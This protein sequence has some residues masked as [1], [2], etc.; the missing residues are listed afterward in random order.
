[1]DKAAIKGNVTYLR[2]DYA[3]RTRLELRA[4]ESVQHQR[5][6]NRIAI[7]E[8]VSQYGVRT[9]AGEFVTRSARL[10]AFTWFNR[11]FSVSA[12][13][14]RGRRLIDRELAREVC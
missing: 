3:A 10:A 2:P 1:M 8:A 9:Q 6:R 11:G 7:W 5:Q 13:I 14:A 12:S 4:P